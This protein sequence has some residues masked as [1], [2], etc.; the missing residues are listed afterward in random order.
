MG[1]P[2][3]TGGGSAQ[4]LLIL[5]ILI[6]VTGLHLS[7]AQSH[8]PTPNPVAVASPFSF[9]FDFTNKSNYRPEDLKFE[10]DATPRGDRV[11]VTC[12]SHGD[13][14][15]NCSGRLSYAHPVPLF[16]STTGEVASF[17]TCFKFL[18]HIDNST[19]KDG[20]MAFFF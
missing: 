4:L 12:D 5:F 15:T 10:G 8:S 6:L 3:S 14:S 18:I 19:S 7:G 16:D 11:D 9:S 13:E 2:A 17:Q 20:G 1:S